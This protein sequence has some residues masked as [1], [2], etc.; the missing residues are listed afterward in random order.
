MEKE[1]DT[2]KVVEE[3]MNRIKELFLTKELAL[4]NEEVLEGQTYEES[5]QGYPDEFSHVG[6]LD[7]IFDTW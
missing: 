2:N 5:Y 1:K 4:E 3:I 7:D 6:D